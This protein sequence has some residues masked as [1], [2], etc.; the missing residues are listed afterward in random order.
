MKFN[1]DKFVKKNTV[2]EKTAKEQDDAKKRVEQQSQADDER[3]RW[4]LKFRERWQNRI[5]YPRR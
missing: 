2:K 3:R 4:L 1:F 5:V